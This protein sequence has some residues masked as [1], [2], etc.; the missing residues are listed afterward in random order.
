ML[1]PYRWKLPSK[2]FEEVQVLSIAP[3]GK[4][5]E[6]LTGWVNGLRASDL[7]E[8]IARAFRTKRLNFEFHHRVRME[9]RVY[10]NDIDFIVNTD[11]VRQAIEVFGPFTH[12]S[13]SNKQKDAARI[14]ELNPVLQ[15]EG[16]EP[17][18]IIWH[19]EITTPEDALNKVN[20]LF[21]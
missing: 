16:I 19:W 20:E 5:E 7:E 4:T 21:F 9:G 12:D 2:R 11:F 17:I 15:K 1:K 14:A 3:E 18:I 10:K 8:R 6:G 13:E